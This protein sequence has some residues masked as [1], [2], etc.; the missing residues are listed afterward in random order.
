MNTSKKRNNSR[1]NCSQSNER[2]EAGKFL[3]NNTG[4]MDAKK[5]IAHLEGEIKKLL[6]KRNVSDSIIEE[7]D[8][9]LSRHTG[10]LARSTDPTMSV[11]DSISGLKVPPLPR[12]RYADRQERYGRNID[13]EEFIAL[14]W[15]DYISHSLLYSEHLRIMDPGLHKALYRRAH[16]EGKKIGDYLFG[17]G[18]LGMKQIK[19]PGPEYERQANLIERSVALARA[20]SFTSAETS[21]RLQEPELDEG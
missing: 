8:E 15:G 4:V 3:T 2:L 5:L 21:E 9:I 6:E 12:T 10:D 16:K 17:L 14:E 18:V 19:D 13:P 1:R 7:V 11:V 20:G